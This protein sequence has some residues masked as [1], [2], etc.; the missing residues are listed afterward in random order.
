MRALLSNTR[1]Y[2]STK[3]H[4]L[5][6]SLSLYLNITLVTIVILM[7]TV[8]V[9]YSQES[10]LDKFPACHG[11]IDY[12]CSCTHNVCWEVK[13]GEFE[14][15]GNGLW[16]YL[17][18]GEVVKQKFWSPDGVFRA[19]AFDPLKWSQGLVGPGNP[20]SCLFPPMPKGS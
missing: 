3:V 6:N 9:V 5:I 19:C 14:S 18:T 11:Y 10:Y 17:Q 12:K 7:L 16:K 8:G 15:L 20:I 4:K 2:L 1:S 13:P